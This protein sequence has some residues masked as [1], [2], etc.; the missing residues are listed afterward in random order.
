MKT[1]LLR[2]IK[3]YLV[4]VAANR[5]SLRNQGKNVIAIARRYLWTLDLSEFS[6]VTESGFSALLNSKTAALQLRFPVLRTKK[7]QLRRLFPYP[8]RNWG[9]P[10]KVLNIFLRDCVHHRDVSEFYGLRTLLPYLELPLDA[11]TALHLERSKRHEWRGVKWLDHEL[12]N[13]FQAR[14]S[15][16]GSRRGLT[17]V[18]LD[19]LWWPGA[20]SKGY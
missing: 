4:Y 14:A 20:K 16:V 5:S 13:E 12:S 19:Y 10:R 18:Q 17:R 9:A 7:P 2:Y 1:E 11:R 8:T 6:G 3:K 15:R